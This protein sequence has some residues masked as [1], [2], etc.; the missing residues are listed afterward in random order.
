VLLRAIATVTEADRCVLASHVGDFGVRLEADARAKDRVADPELHEQLSTRLRE[1]LDRLA[2]D[3]APDASARLAAAQ[4]LATCGEDGAEWIGRLVDAEDLTAAI[5]AVWAL[6]LARGDASKIRDRLV[7]ALGTT[8]PWVRA[9]AAC[10]LLDLHRE[11]ADARS[12]LEELA[13]STDDV[14]AN[15]CRDALAKYAPTPKGGK[16]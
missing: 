14:L 15:F 4:A 8:R 2:R 9:N 1:S 6:R 13:A 16:K 7:R 10:S 12:T 3:V 5:D 11:M